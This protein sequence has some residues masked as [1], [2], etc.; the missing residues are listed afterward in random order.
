MS[1]KTYKQFLSDI[2]AEMRDAYEER[3][4]QLD[5][6][7]KSDFSEK[8][9]KQKREEINS[10]FDSKMKEFEARPGYEEALKSARYEWSMKH[11]Y[12]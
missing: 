12:K 4:E 11:K 6:V 3:K 7:N 2:W 5:E 1:N 10:V 8:L 9:K